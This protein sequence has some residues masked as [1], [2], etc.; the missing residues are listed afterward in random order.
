HMISNRAMLS[1]PFI[2]YAR[3]DGLAIG[4]GKAESWEPEVIS[5]EVRWVHNYRGLWGLDTHDPIG[6]ERAPAG[7]KYNRDGSVRQSWYDPIG[8]AGLDKVFPLDKVDA[9]LEDRLATLNVELTDLKRL[10]EARR[11]ALRVL[12]LDAEALKVTKYFN[13]LRTKKE[14]ELKLAQADLQELQERR[15]ELVETRLALESYG[16]RLERGDVGSPTA[17][18]QHVHHP[19]P[20]LPQQHRLVEIWAAVSG[21]IILLASMVLLILRPG[22]WLVWIVGL[23]LV[24]AAVEALTR[25]RFVDYMLNIIIVLAVIAALIL[26]Y[27]FW[28]WILA[29]GLAGVALF[30]IWGNLQEL[31][32]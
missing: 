18:L 9:E 31:R 26:V 7:P 10:I 24:L 16:R 5:D 11:E 30:M 19:E 32:R 13:V 21:A 4:P 14:E 1:V 29:L 2:D 12:A 23:T 28:I 15:A 25:G 6:G 20:P 8:W 22:N 3:G 27:E 17:H